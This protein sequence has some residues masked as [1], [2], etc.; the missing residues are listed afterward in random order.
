MK[1]QKS[2]GLYVVPSETGGAVNL[3]VGLKTFR[4][5]EFN[6]FDEAID[7]FR[8]WIS[9]KNPW[10]HGFHNRIASVTHKPVKADGFFW[11][12]FQKKIWRSPCPDLWRWRENTPQ[13]KG[14]FPAP[15]ATWRMRFGAAPIVLT[16][17]EKPVDNMAV[18]FMSKVFVIWVKFE[19]L[20]MQGEYVE[21]HLY[22]LSCKVETQ[23]AGSRWSWL[24]W[25]G[26]K[27]M[28]FGCWLI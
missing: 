27:L 5:A 25:Q 16:P 23:P 28:L 9:E 24:N 2:E 22:P 3:V 26:I 14:C 20:R 10:N 17:T 11:S 15:S 18:H 19:S 6:N 12:L 7:R 4:L 8:F 13:A 21:E 1:M